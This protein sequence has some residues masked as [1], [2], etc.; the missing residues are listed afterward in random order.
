[1]AK[2]EDYL[3]QEIDD[4]AAQQRARDE[5]GRYIPERF[6]G[7]DISDVIKSYEEL[8]K[9]N[10]RQA[11]DLGTMRRQVDQLL[12]AQIQASSPTPEPSKP[13]SVDDLYEDAD[14]NIRRV[15]KEEAS[16]EI[17]AL[18]K[19]LQ[20]MRAQQRLAQ[21]GEKFPEWQDRVTQPEFKTWM[22]ASPY[23]VRLVQE[24]DKGDLDA[25][26]EVLG[27]YYDTLR[28][29]EREEVE[30][31][32]REAALKDAILESG[33]PPITEMVDT[34]SRSELLEKRLAAKRG[35]LQ[36]ERWLQ[37][38]ANSIASAYEEGRIVD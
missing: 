37:A 29:E 11:Q 4:A 12:E 18:K 2:Y 23:R 38:H 36:A 7:K 30:A 19:E 16:G 26:E 35:N 15:V 33:S 25:A 6:A 14:G 27:M 10:S 21:I 17:E 24:A 22:E 28:T 5:K 8:E 1:M 34:Y 20:A 32:N 9:L 31:Q 13:V 3:A